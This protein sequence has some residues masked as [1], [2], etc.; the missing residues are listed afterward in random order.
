MT[1]QINT[2]IVKKKNF[3]EKVNPSFSNPY[4]SATDRALRNGESVF[5]IAKSSSAPE[6]SSK[7]SNTAAIAEGESAT[8]DAN[9]KTEYCKNAGI[10]LQEQQKN[11]ESSV[12]NAELKNK[13][14]NSTIK[15]DSNK[16]LS[17][18]TE[19]K[20]IDNEIKDLESERDSLS[21]G[22]DFY[23]PFDPTDNGITSFY[24]LDIGTPDNQTTGSNK[25]GTIIPPAQDNK[26]NPNQERLDEINAQIESKSGKKEA[27]Y[28]KAGA[29]SK[30][31]DA[32]Y[33][34]NLKQLA[35]AKSEAQKAAKEAEAEKAK[36][37]GEMMQ[38]AT[39]TQTIGG[40]LTATGTA[41][42]AT[43]VGAEIGIPM[44]VTGGITT[45]AGFGLNLAASATA[46]DANNALNSA[47]NGL[48]AL[49]NIKKPDKPPVKPA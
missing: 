47:T 48:N 38:F 21:G 42:C 28:K 27:V 30:N 40:T 2:D 45:A 22:N 8:N 46:G 6:G 39:T 35:F 1:I 20:K 5:Y 7:D 11:I 3:N 29:I 36:A 44:Q 25:P 41:L 17:L 49:T 34:N 26:N 12:K 43:G 9:S 37:A 23:N 18:S 33:K 10:K 19:G 13:E 16:L 31:M 15:S 24:S 4:M 32:A 14:A